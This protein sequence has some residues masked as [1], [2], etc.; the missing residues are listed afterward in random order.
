MSGRTLY[1]GDVHGCAHELERLLTV[2]Q[3][4]RVVLVGDLFTKGPDPRGV[5]ELVQ[6]HRCEAVLGNHDQ[7][8]L[9]QPDCVDLPRKAYKWLAKR[10]CFLV[11]P[12]IVVVHAGLHPTRGVSG[13]TRA[14]AL[15]M[16]FWPLGGQTLWYDRY[17]RRQ[18]VVF[19]HD[20]V[21]G[22][23]RRDRIVGLDSGCV[24][25]GQLS[26][27]LREEDRVLSV[28]AARGYAPIKAAAVRS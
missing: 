26:G 9:E 13:T 28:P 25:G 23:V 12:G 22:L 18:T 3:A 2:A 11:E 17:D 21:R 7:R 20:A 5:W 4:D 6:E 27:W 16:R 8:V 19:G 24:Y 14:M 15:T 10:P 1:V